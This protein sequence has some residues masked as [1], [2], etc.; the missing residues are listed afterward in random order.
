VIHLTVQNSTVGVNAVHQ[1]SHHLYIT[2]QK[3][4]EARA[5]NPSNLMDPD[6]PLVNFAKYFD[7]E[8]LDQ[9]DLYVAQVGWA[10]V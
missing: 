5:S 8:S 6:D 7:G 9:E 3:D 4:T 10:L 2:R 1:A